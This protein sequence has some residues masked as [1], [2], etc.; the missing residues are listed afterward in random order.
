[1]II[2][3]ESCGKEKDMLSWQKVCYPCQEEAYKEK[4]RA[5]IINGDKTTTENETDVYCPYCGGIYEDDWRIYEEGWHDFECGFCE[6]SFETKTEISHSF[7]TY[8][9]DNK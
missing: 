7:S 1:M 4:I 8:R 9:I 6:K 2:R 3:C 5:G